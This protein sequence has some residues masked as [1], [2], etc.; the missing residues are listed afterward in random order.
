M[1]V[2]P[3][4]APDPDSP[5]AS[6]PL[7]RSR[8]RRSLWRM[9]ALRVL[10]VPLLLVGAGA[11]AWGQRGPVVEATALFAMEWA[12]LGPAALTVEVVEADH[13]VLSSVS[14]AGGQARAE[15]IAVTYSLAGLGRVE[16]TG[17]EMS[18]AWDPDTG[19]DA[20]P[21]SRWLSG[22]GGGSGTPALPF[23]SLSLS[24]ARLTLD[25][26]EGPIRALGDAALIAEQ[27][28]EGPEK[29]ADLSADLTVSGAGLFAAANIQARP[30]PDL[31]GQAL[32]AVQAETRDRPGLARGLA[33]GGLLT[34]DWAD[35]V[36][37]VTTESLRASAKALDPA[38]LA[39]LPQDLAELAEGPLSLSLE[40]PDGDA[41][42]DTV[43]TRL[44]LPVGA[45]AEAGE[46]GEGSALRLDGHLRAETARL[47]LS[48]GV[49]VSMMGGAP[50]LSNVSGTLTDVVVHGTGLDPLVPVAGLEGLAA[51][52]TSP[53]LTLDAGTLSGL[54]AFS[55][56]GTGINA[57]VAKAGAAHLDAVGSVALTMQG[58]TV[59]LDAVTLDLTDPA[60]PGLWEGMPR[61]SLAL[62]DGRAHTVTL[63]LSGDLLGGEVP[64]VML[65]ATLA[66]FALQGPVEA[67]IE[68]VRVAGRV[69]WR[70]DD[71]LTIAVTVPTARIGEWDVNEAA[72]DFA[73][74]PDSPT[75]SV[76][77]QLPRLPGEASA[78]AIARHP[79]RPL[80]ITGRAA[81]DPD[82]PDR[83]SVE[84]SVG[85]PL[86]DTLMSATGWIDRDGR[87]GRLR[88]SSGSPITLGRGGVQPWHLHGSLK[89]LSASAGSLA[90]EGTMA[91]SGGGAMR[92]DLSFALAGVDAAFGATQLRQLSGVVHLTSLNPP[93]SPSQELVA[94]GLNMGLPFSDVVM[95]Y[96]LNGAGAFVLEEAHMKFAGGDIT[97]DSA[98]IPLA[99]FERV[100]LTLTVRGV[101]LSQLAAMTPI[102]NLSVTG[103]VDGQVP[104][105]ITPGAV[106]IDA[107]RLAAMGPG[108]VQY[109]G[110]ALPS[111]GGAGEGVDL[112]SRALE[113]F[114]YTDLS[115]T[116]GG[117]T[118]DDMSVSLRLEGANEHVLDGYP[119]QLNLNLSGPL[120][121]IIQ[122]G[123]QGYTIPKR[124]Q[125]RLSRFG[126]E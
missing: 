46:A 102:D 80:R 32:M 23:E 96:R 40:T 17:A 53:R 88:F 45:L 52:L 114:H 85:A 109:R 110:T 12:G 68:S 123:L 57:D 70:A 126:L 24:G 104:M 44:V 10:P 124:I 56:A 106:Q 11:L 67:R 22:G 75:L 122:E 73:F 108:V 82:D 119:F 74:R 79:L 117:S 89:D 99:G 100:P 41:L 116:V 72:A 31:R 50:A 8:R 118:E 30:W 39:I 103:T 107:G 9:V 92:P 76:S 51:D 36:L 83:F 38:L 35:G 48:T 66:P 5:D 97:T 60:L 20:G 34:L 95:R 61:L 94:A 19:L 13:V 7:K 55:A 86:R 4:S 26:P 105:V 115:M 69:P 58:G 15:R 49:S 14:L 113:D 71:P 125:E 2:A 43:P 63:D 16:I 111:G 87:D 112:A 28:G 47:S 29:G 18:A 33:G 77:A 27:D 21:F 25:T 93:R 98:T 59:T 78:G 37:T 62:E 64:A 6:S 54:F 120:T 101:D 65:D 121:R 42:G 3:D 1:T 90:V 81:P 84:A 91:W